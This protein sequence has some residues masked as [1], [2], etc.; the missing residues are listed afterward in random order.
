MTLLASVSKITNV[1]NPSGWLSITA[2]VIFLEFVFI[3]VL[4]PLSSYLRKW[5]DRFGL[6]AVMADVGILLIGFALTRF[7][8]SHF[9][10]ST[11]PYQHLL[12]I[13]MFLAVQITHDIVYYFALVK[14]YSG[15]NTILNY[16]KDYGRDVGVK[17]IIGDS[18]MVVSMT[19]FAY[20]LANSSKEINIFVLLLGI[21]CIP[22]ALS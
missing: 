11:L 18:A 15:K 14:P 6:L 8:Y 17:A 22:Y 1:S 16:M 9:K 7:I 20:V 13:A 10:L 4:K 12:F 5:Y 19:L 3:M 2:S 21:Y